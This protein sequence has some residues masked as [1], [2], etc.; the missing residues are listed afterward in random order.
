M[1]RTVVTGLA[2]LL[3]LAI[4]S[5][6]TPPTDLVEG[7]PLGEGRASGAEVTV[8]APVPTTESASF[9]AADPHA[10][11]DHFAALWVRGDFDALGELADPQ[12]LDEARRIGRIRSA[13]VRWDGTCLAGSLGSGSCDVEILAEAGSAVVT[14]DYVV[15]PG[16]GSYLEWLHSAVPA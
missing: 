15:D 5:C 7:E 4:G 2:L 9:D 10:L 3:T 6:G 1:S 11:L 8:R 14:V 12:V 13:V 16:S